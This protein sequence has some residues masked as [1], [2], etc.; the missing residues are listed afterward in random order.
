M[1]LSWLIALGV[2][3][4]CAPALAQIAPN[5][6][7]GGEM[8]PAGKSDCFVNR[9]YSTFQRNFSLSVSAG[10]KAV[11]TFPAAYC[12]SADLSGQAVLIF[13][14]ATS[15][16][17]RFKRFPN[18]VAGSAGLSFA[19]Y[20]ETIDAANREIA[21]RFEIVGAFPVTLVLEAP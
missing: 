10:A 14:N 17:I 8:A 15:G 11:I 3:A 18:S 2:L 1:R 5:A 6:M 12:Q 19:N 21:V 9:G 20:S 7:L 13:N 4:G 16:N